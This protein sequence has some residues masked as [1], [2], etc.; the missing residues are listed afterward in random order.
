V[1]T[2][3]EHLASPPTE[4][5]P[6][7]DRNTLIL[8]ATT[9]AQTIT[10]PTIIIITTITAIM[11]LMLVVMVC[12]LERDMSPAHL[13]LLMTRWAVAAAVERT[14]VGRKVKESERRIN[15]NPTRRKKW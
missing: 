8:M 13:R 5:L 15:Q 3:E 1:K 6:L 4:L 10:T 9:T 12:L 11:V 7:H 14:A 2:K